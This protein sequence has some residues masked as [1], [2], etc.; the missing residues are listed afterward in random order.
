MSKTINDYTA[1]TT[2]DA[3]ADYLLIE[4]SGPVYKKINRNT[5]L[6]LT[7]APVGLTDSQTLTNKTLTSPTISGPTLSGTL[8]GTYTI[9][10]T[11][12]FPSSVVQLTS[13]QTLTNKT[14]TSPT[15][16]GGTIDNAT[17]TVD[18]I[19]GHST[20]TIV[21]IANLQI[22]NGVLNTNNSVVTAN[23]TD[24]AVTPAKLQS[25]TGSG[26]AWSTWTPTLTNLTLGNGTMTARYIQT[27]KM[28]TLAIAFSFGS[29]SSLSGGPSFS[30]PVT[31]RTGIYG[32]GFPI[33]WAVVKAG[34]GTNTPSTTMYNSSTTLTVQSLRADL[35]NAYYQVFDS[36]HPGTWTTG[37]FMYI[38]AT[39][40]AA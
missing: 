16:S 10:G 29:T 37:D 7:S 5:L 21:T 39:Y 30:L 35:T 23:I 32:S 15:I 6:G 19:S 33:G 28:V 26:W 40:E 31:A 34:G 27:G 24:A 13:T 2:I 9:G 3:T 8:S 36:T 11:P 38:M 25:G 20:S 17:I 1:A 18:S 12:T 4:Q 14:L 22:S